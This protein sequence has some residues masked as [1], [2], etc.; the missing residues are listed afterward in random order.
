[1]LVMGKGF[2][3]GVKSVQAGPG[4]Q[5][6]PAFSI[7]INGP[8]AVVA[9]TI[10]IIL[11]GLIVLELVAVKTAQASVGGNPHKTVRVL[12][13]ATPNPIAGQPVFRGK[14]LKANRITAL[15][16]KRRGGKKP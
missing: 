6:D 14:L 15:S 11:M 13:N 5:P 9:Q 3:R 10:G 4:R 1:M 2:S 7:D 12:D 16:M 8:D